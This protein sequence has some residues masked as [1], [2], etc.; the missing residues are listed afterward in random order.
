MKM[1]NYSSIDMAIHTVADLEKALETPRPESPFLVGEYQLKAIRELSK[2][3]DA[4]TK[5]Q[6][7]IH[8]PPPG[9]C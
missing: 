7:G 4:E 5:S 9:P 8:F 1:P 3:F 6:T 2:V